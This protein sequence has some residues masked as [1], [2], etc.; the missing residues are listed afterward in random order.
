[1]KFES[2][3]LKE[4]MER[5]YSVTK[6]FEFFTKRENLVIGKLKGEE[7]MVEYVCPH[8]GFYEIKEVKMEKRKGGKRFKR[9]KFKCGKCGRTIVV[10]DLRKL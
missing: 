2:R 3:L 4:W 10:E 1:M 5:G 9:P 6:D 8:C 7:A